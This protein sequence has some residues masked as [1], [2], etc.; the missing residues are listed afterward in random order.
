[1]KRII[2]YSGGLDSFICLWLLRRQSDDWTPVYFDLNLR[3]TTKEIMHMSRADG[4][5]FVL[6][7]LDLGEL[8]RHDAYVPQR[9]VMLCAAAQALY[10]ASEIALCS[11]ADDVYADNTTEFHTRMAELLSHTAGYPVRVFSPL[12]GAGLEALTKVE[13]VAEYLRL[14]GDPEMLRKTVSCYDPVEVSCGR[15]KACTRRNAA[16]A[17]NGI[18]P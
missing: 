18:T 9:N 5:N 12:L 2:L 15:C 4:L 6:T 13:A 14:G 8:E 11:V 10:S 1:M 3:Y 16:L 7:I 17:A